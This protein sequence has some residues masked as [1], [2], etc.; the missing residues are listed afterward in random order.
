MERR[1][2]DALIAGGMDWSATLD[3][4]G[5]NE[6]LLLKYLGRFRDDPSF[7]A[8]QADVQHSDW[9]SAEVS[10]H[11][12][13]GISGNLGLTPLYHACSTMMTL[14]RGQDNAGAAATFETVQTE[15]RKVFAL[16]QSL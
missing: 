7:A 14:L 9:A 6:A 13:K 10:C 15:Y 8:L 4:F 5:G 1:I 2:Q 16:L 12:L 3:R 11:T